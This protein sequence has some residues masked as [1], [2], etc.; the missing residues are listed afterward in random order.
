MER[1]QDKD[2]RYF[3]TIDRETM[4]VIGHDYEQKHYLD[5]GRQ[6]SHATHRLFVTKGQYQKFVER[7]CS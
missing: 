1:I 4:K 5:K 7:C 6:P 3:L 2:T